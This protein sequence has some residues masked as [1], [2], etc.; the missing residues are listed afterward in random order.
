MTTSLIN[1]AGIPDLAIREPA[2][3]EVERVLYLLR[4]VPLNPQ[5]R[6]MAVARSHPIERFI[7]AAAWWPEGTIGRF[8][9]ACQPGVARATVAGLLIERLEESARQAGMKSIGCVTL[10]TED[11]DWFEILRSHGF[12]HLHS[13]RSFEVSYRVAWTRVMQ[14]QQKHRSQFPAGWRTESIRNHPPEIALD[15]IASHRLMPSDEIRSYWQSGSAFG[16]EPDLSCILFDGQRPFG[17]FLTRRI[18]ERLYIDVQVVEESNPLLRSLASLFLLYHDA[19]RIAPDGPIRWIWFRSG[20]T[21][22]RQT[23]NLAL[24][25]GGREVARSHLMTKTLTTTQNGAIT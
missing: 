24:R 9:L 14:L 4:E 2:P 17:V 6:L 3:A 16:F 23:A 18:G 5:A 19:Q 21:E 20:Q 13:E 15:L 10:L 1:K 12:E 11:N 7:A 25:M 8:Q 22:H